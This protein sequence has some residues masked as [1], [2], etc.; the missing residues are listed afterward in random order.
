MNRWKDW[1][2]SFARVTR[3]RKGASTV[4]YVIILAAAALIGGFLYTAVT[5][6]Q[7]EST[8]QQ[9]I[10]DAIEGNVG[11]GQENGAGSSLSEKEPNNNG[12]RPHADEKPSKEKKPTKT[13]AKSHQSSSKAD[14]DSGGAYDYLASGEMVDD[15]GYVAKET[16]D[17]LFLD[18][19][20][21][22]INGKDTDGNK[23]SGFD[24]GIS[25]VSAVPI[26]AAKLAKG[27]KYGGKALDYTKKLDNSLSKT[28]AGKRLKKS[29]GK[30]DEVA[31]RGKKKF[32]C[33]CD[34]KVDKVKKSN[35]VDNILEGATPGRAT[36][37]KAKQYEKAGGF[38][39]ARKDFNSLG[40]TNVKEIP[41][42]Y[43]GKLP[44]GRTVNVRNKSSDGRPTL[45]I[46][47]GKKSTKIRYK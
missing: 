46:Y 38:D 12:N 45:E 23:V 27:V 9:K 41:G 35:S 3:S 47:E 5:S 40:V 25:C 43:V 18:D 7:T 37:G 26:P 16:L 22:C 13:N 15:A 33:A 39:Q 10:D 20:S 44:D 32:K 30:V 4:E 31:E 11:G 34:D 29:K 8:I 21:G 2:E 19:L 14:D 36:K 28:Q 17:F 24:R 1:L 6:D 42:G